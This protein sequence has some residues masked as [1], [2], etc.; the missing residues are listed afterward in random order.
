MKKVLVMCIL[1]ALVVAGSASANYIW[2]FAATNASNGNAGVAAQWG[3]FSPATSTLATWN[4]STSA[5]A[6]EVVLADAANP[7]T[8]AKTSL[9]AKDFVATGADRTKMYL[10]V[11]ARSDF[12]GNGI[13]LRAWCSS[14]ADPAPRAQAITVKCVYDPNG[15]LTNTVLLSGVSNATTYTQVA[16]AGKYTLPVFKSETP[17]AVGQGYILEVTVPEPGSMIAMLSGLV[18][19]VG[20][21]IRRRK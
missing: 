3:Y 20:F 11:W 14:N 16:P 10:Q 21:G 2:K 5:Y 18:G 19:L 15:A 6:A 13:D 7:G 1:L 8:S 17:G 4:T 9:L 12:A